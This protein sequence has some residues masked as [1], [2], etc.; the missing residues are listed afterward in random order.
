[1]RRAPHL[2][3]VDEPLARMLTDATGFLGRGCQ[4]REEDLREPPAD[5]C[6]LLPTPADSCR[7][8]IE[9]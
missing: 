7:R 8:V 1:V 6:R 5:S 9:E 2:G 4:R 3:W